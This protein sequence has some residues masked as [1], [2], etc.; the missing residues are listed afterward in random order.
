MKMERYGVRRIKKLHWNRTDVDISGYSED[1]MA[2][3]HPRYIMYCVMCVLTK[4]TQ[5]RARHASDIL[6]IMINK[7]KSFVCF[8]TIAYNFFFFFISQTDS[9]RVVLKIA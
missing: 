8:R 5:K 7:M 6:R 9:M 1:T 3:P 2:L 4:I